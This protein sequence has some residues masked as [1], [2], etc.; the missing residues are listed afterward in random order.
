MVGDAV[1][2]ECPACW[3]K[4][5][6]CPKCSGSGKVADRQLSPNFKLSE[7]VGSNT[8]KAKGLANDPTPE[9]EEALEDLC[10]EALEP[11][12]ALVGPLKV[13]SGYRS[14]AVN[15]AVGGS[16]SSAHC[17]GH[18]AD[19]VPLKCTWKQAM[20]K[21][22]EAKLELDQLIYEHTW[23]HVGHVHP[24]TKGKRGDLLTMFKKDGKVTYEE[25][26]ANDGRL[27]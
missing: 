16:K 20:D 17:H 23:L 6:A 1:T 8:A 15:K 21:V 25:Y 27:A 22:V 5:K 12:R 14:E 4:K 18:A 9:I 7:L 13:N 26:D 19:V 24:K 10:K 11:M 3:G 2:M